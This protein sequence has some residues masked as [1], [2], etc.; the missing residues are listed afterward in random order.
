MIPK[1]LAMHKDRQDSYNE[2]VG[3]TDAYGSLGGKPTG[4][5]PPR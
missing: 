4:S 3:M 5:N 2:L 1:L